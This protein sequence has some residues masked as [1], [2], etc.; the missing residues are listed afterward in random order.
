MLGNIRLVMQRIISNKHLRY[1]LPFLSFL[2]VGWIGVREFA[3][4]RYDIKKK[5]GESAA[6][7]ERL[8][9][10]GISSK[11]KRTTAEEEYEAMVHNTDLDSWFNIRGPR[12]DEDS[13]T[14]QTQMRQEHYEQRSSTSVQS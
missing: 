4:I 6:F 3:Q 11:K 5:F 13:R 2:V 10:A 7:Q 9:Q 12:P 1:G 14:I 8:E